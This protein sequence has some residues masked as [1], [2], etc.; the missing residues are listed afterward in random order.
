M[1]QK[2]ITSPLIKMRCLLDRIDKNLSYDEA[3]ELKNNML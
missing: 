3:E 1:K 2:Y